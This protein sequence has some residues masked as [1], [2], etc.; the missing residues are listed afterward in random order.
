MQLFFARNPQLSMRKHEGTSI[1]RATGYNASKIRIFEEVLK[2]ELF[3]EDRKRRIAPEN[4]FNVDETGLMMNQNPRKIVA[5]KGKKTVSV[6][7]SAKGKTLTAVCCIS[8]AGVHRPPL[9]IFP[10]ND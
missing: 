7:T 3:A 8:A 4:I 6:V 1:Q 10:Q 9:L 2:K 5:K